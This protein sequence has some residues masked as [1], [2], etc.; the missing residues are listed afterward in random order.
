VANWA[1][2]VGGG[3]YRI[4]GKLENCI[5]ADNRTE[6]GDS[7]LAVSNVI[8]DINHCN[9]RGGQGAV[10]LIDPYIINWG[11]GNID[12]DPCFVAG[13]YWGDVNDVN[14]IVEPSHPNAVWVD[15]DYHLL[16]GSPCIDTGDP[17]YVGEPNET[18]LDGCLRV[19]DGNNDG[20]AIID[21][22][23]YEYLPPIEAD[24]RITPRVLNLRSRG[25]FI[26]AVIR[27]PEPYKVADIDQSSV[28]L[29]G[30]IPAG[31]TAIIESRNVAVARFNC[32]DLTDLLELT[33]GPIE[34][35]V[36]GRLNDQTPFEGTDTIRINSKPPK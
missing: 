23:A 9:I 3:A 7:Q 2:S 20:L 33:P 10:Q 13:G 21:M 17:N 30:Q 25:R 31:R 34:L 18:D 29:E 27:L 36:T 28:M 14:V 15:G 26:L 11:P 1:G 6:S 5:F 4:F 8:T 22:G 32:R 16:S 12:A 35:T 24:I 19:V